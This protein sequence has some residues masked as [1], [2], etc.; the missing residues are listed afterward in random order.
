MSSFDMARLPDGSL[1]FSGRIDAIEFVR[2]N[3]T[4]HD[5]ALLEDCGSHDRTAADRLLALELLF[6]RIAEQQF[7]IASTITGYRPEQPA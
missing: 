6:R 2:L 7:D 4:P 5:R 1:T 3:L